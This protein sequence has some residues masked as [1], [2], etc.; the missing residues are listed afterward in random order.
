MSAITLTHPTAGP[1]NTP[2]ALAL[3]DQ[4][5][6]PDEFTWAPVLQ[7]SEYTTTGALVLDAWA[8]QAGR[9]ITLQA[10]QD[11]AWCPRATASTLRTWVAQPGQTF[12]LALRGATH[13]VV[14][15]HEG[16]GAMGA[17]PVIDFSDPDDADY[18][19]L[20]LRFLEI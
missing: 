10:A 20:T 15:N 13:T 7:T 6:W 9:P 12:T 18:Y 14:F 5:S 4:L 16:G 1:A 11:R 2:L 8:K 3:P 17:E 19:I